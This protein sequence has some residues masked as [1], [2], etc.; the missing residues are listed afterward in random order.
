[1][2]TTKEFTGFCRQDPSGVWWGVDKAAYVRV[3]GY[4]IWKMKGAVP[5]TDDATL[6]R[7]AVLLLSSV[8]P[9]A[10][11][12][13]HGVGVRYQDGGHNVLCLDS[14][15]REAYERQSLPVR[16]SR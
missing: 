12:V 15:R 16:N 9:P 14:A 13:V 7:I 1:M 5:I 3:S 8:E 6:A 10:N 2:S 11:V 4:D